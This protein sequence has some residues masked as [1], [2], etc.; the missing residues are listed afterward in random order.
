MEN[1]HEFP[2]IT[3]SIRSPWARGR[4]V[5]AP[6]A[7]AAAVAVSEWAAPPAADGPEAAARTAS[8]PTVV[9]PPWTAGAPVARRSCP[10]AAVP[11]ARPRWP[12]TRGKRARYQVAWSRWAACRDGRWPPPWLPPRSGQ[13]WG[14]GA[15]PARC[16]ASRDCWRARVSG[17]PRPRTAGS[18]PWAV[19]GA[20]SR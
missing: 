19:P 15:S 12:A 8:C 11:R 9:S 2:S 14:R 3:S 5:P 4:V 17:T 7:A 1:V 18:A 10:G 20:A 16:S 13:D 6:R